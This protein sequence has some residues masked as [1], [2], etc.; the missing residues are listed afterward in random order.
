[1]VQQ[2]PPTTPEVT[3][4][5]PHHTGYALLQRCLQSV[6]ASQGVSFHVILVTSAPVTEHQ[7]FLSEFGADRRFTYWY[8][9]GGPAHKRNYG[10]AHGGE[11]QSTYVVFLDDDVEVSPYCL[12]EFYLWMEDHPR[13]GM[14]FAKIYKMEEGRRDE[15]DD[16]G[17]WL[18]RSGFLFARSGNGQVDRGQFDKPCR[19]LS[20]KSATC[21][22]RNRAFMDVTGFDRDYFILGEET[23]MAWRMWL[24]GWEVW[25]VPTATS[26]H[27]FGCESLK[28][29]LTYYTHE[30]IF[31]RGCK[32]YLSLLFTNLGLAKLYA[33]LPLHL[34]L[35]ATA[36]VGF[37]FRKGGASCAV[38]IMRGMQDFFLSLPSL[39]RKR[40]H[41]QSTRVVSDRDLWPL[42]SYTPPLTYYWHRL[43]RYV[44]QGLHG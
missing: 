18:T 7:Q 34:S 5:I 38:Q 37:C 21:V 11:V 32:N 39:Q 28:P 2:T 36:A 44:S 41:V 42:I 3:V 16:C 19:C 31:Y 17:S 25:Y 22:V 10:V 12:Y 27:A 15:F 4:I 9:Q 13:C 29:K 43:R 40:H 35:W 6:L 14:A 1:M 24:K 30:R 26:W 8:E 20:S 23:D 33:I